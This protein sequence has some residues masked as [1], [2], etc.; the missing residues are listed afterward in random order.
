MNLYDKLDKP[1]K[2][3]LTSEATSNRWT[4][5]IE[6]K[7][8]A[9]F[10]LPIKCEHLYGFDDNWTEGMPNRARCFTMG[11]AL[12]VGVIIKIINHTH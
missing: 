10:L 11:N 9:R 5:I 12:I 3:M 6:T 1:A 7:Q 4:H 2:T 8:R